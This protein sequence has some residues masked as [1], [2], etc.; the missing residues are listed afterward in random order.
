MRSGLERLAYAVTIIVVATLVGWIVAMAV[1]L[2]PGTLAAMPLPPLVLILLRI[3]TSFGGVFGFSIMFNSTPKM[4]A[5]AGL[6]GAV[7]NT[8]RLE[9]VDYSSIP[10]GACAFIGALIAGLLAVSYTHLTLPTI[11]LV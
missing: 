2:R 6:I 4:A 7:A 3:V 8:T 11:L 1:R 5:V 10:A 9:L